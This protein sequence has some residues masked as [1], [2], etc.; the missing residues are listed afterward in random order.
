[1]S[2]HFLLRITLTTSL[3]IWGK[4]EVLFCI[5]CWGN[6]SEESHGEKQ[7]FLIWEN[8]LLEAIILFG[9]CF[10]RVCVWHCRAVTW[11][12]GPGSPSPLCTQQSHFLVTSLDH[13]IFTRLLWASNP[14]ILGVSASVFPRENWKVSWVKLWLCGS[15]KSQKF[16]SKQDSVVICWRLMLIY[17]IWQ[18]LWCK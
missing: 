12:Q 1:M 10:Y 14:N 17:S 16:N 9:C 18:F 4:Q 3:E 15:R 13:S 8:L 6:V 7:M 5:K 2:S 11:W